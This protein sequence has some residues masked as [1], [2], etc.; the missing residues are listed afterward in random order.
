MDPEPQKTS[1]VWQCG[2]QLH[3]FGHGRSDVQSA[4]CGTTTTCGDREHAPRRDDVRRPDATT[5]DVRRR[6]DASKAQARVRRRR[7]GRFWSSMQLAASRHD[8]RHRRCTAVAI[9][10]GRRRG[11]IDWCVRYLERLRDASSAA[12]G[13]EE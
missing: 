4:R 7:H 6:G 10:C 13:G 12:A 8:Q 11:A 5:C 3:A 9:L 2:W 1:D